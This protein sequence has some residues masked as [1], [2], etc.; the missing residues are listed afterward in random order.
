[1]T[2]RSGRSE[3][4]SRRM[5]ALIVPTPVTGPAQSWRVSSSV[6]RAATMSTSSS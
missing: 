5:N 2:G 6:S 1:M 4:R 3:E